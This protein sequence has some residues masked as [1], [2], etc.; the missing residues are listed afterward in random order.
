M[1]SSGDS[2]SAL[3]DAG[4]VLSIIGGVL[5]LIV[6]AIVLTIVGQIMAGGSLPPVPHISWLPDL[7]V[8]LVF[9]PTRVIIV[10]I[11][12]LVLGVIAMIGGVSAIRRKSFSLSLAGA[13]GAI[14][15]V[16]LGVI[17]V[18]FVAL[19]KRESRKQSSNSI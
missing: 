12:V 1:A 19:G 8:W 15:A 9:F 13:I 17:A 14:P 16:F 18:T 3:L 4:G 10:G 6:G 5:E 2:R 11:L 7:E